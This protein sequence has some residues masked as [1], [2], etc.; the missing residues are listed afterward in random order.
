M[1]KSVQRPRRAVD[2]PAY[3]DTRG[4]SLRDRTRNRLRRKV[5]IDLGAG[6]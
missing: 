3:L 6:V 5:R 1:H 4:D 2:H